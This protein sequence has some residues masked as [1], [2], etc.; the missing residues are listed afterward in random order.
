MLR[1]PGLLLLL[2]VLVAVAAIAY[3]KLY[4]TEPPP[5]FQDEEEN[6]LFE[7]IGN[8]E[9][10]GIPYWVWLV[11][12]RVFPEYLPRPGGYAALGLLAKDAHEMPVGLTKVTIGYERVGTNCALCHTASV[13]ATPTEAPTIVAAAP[14]QQLAWQQYQRF[15][16]ACASDPRFT[17]DTLLAEISKNT[18]LSLLDRAL[19]RLVIIPRTRTALRRLANADPSSAPHPA[20]GAGRFDAVNAAK[21][22]L[23]SQP[24]D[25]TIGTADMPAIWNLRNHQAFGWD[26]LNTSLQETVVSWAVAG[27]TPREW[28][29]RD[30]AS[31]NDARASRLR[32][33][34]E[35]VS[36]TP[37]AKYPFGVE[38][39]L[40]ASGRVV[41][42]R[43]CAMCHA[44]GGARTGTVIPTAEVGTDPHRVDAWTAAEA[45]AFNALGDGHAWKFSTF[46]KTG[47]YLAGPLDG[48]WLR[49]P[50]LHNG[51]VPSIADLL[52]PP[53]ARP[54]R[55]WRGDDVYDPARLGFVSSGPEAERVGTAFDVPAPGNGNGGHLYGTDLSAADKRAL[56]EFLKTL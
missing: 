55:F 33:L 11:L 21:I 37:P 24:G 49:A 17:A 12:P 25:A 10:Q 30:V 40:A 42:T 9:P 22:G 31:W 38:A 29:D 8:E 15:L 27:G 41:F 6:F 45:A 23:L 52:E 46:R 35:F 5:S 4:R 44:A 20:A 54:S 3:V 36:G 39:Q 47:G 14:A 32:R 18:T 53:S 16:A 51:S 43:S 7:T 26:G 34:F 50:Y 48:A 2:A 1:R 56:I 28:I 19:Y 13:R